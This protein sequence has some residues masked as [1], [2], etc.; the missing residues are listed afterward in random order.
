MLNARGPPAWG[1]TEPRLAETILSAPLVGH[2]IGVFET[3][4]NLHL[5][6]RQLLDFFQERLRLRNEQLKLF[7]YPLVVGTF[8][9]LASGIVVFVVPMFKCIYSNHRPDLFWMTR[10]LVRLS[11][12]IYNE[13]VLWFLGVVGLVAGI[14]I[15]VRFSGWE[16]LLNAFPGCAGLDRLSRM[17]LYS[18]SMELQLNC[19]IPLEVALLESERLFSSHQKNLKK[20]RS[21]IALGVSIQEAFSRHSGFPVYF[22]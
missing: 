9:V 1:V 15:A 8:F 14:G 13:P 20:V 18:R 19:G 21:Q 3:S 17:L 11:D 5:E 16:G 2:L 4:E 10:V 6:F 7:Y 12:S 22:S